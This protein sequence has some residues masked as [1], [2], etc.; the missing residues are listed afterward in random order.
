M[1]NH[2]MEHCRLQVNTTSPIMLEVVVVET[3]KQPI[4]I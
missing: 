4:G 2:R 1:G 3:Q